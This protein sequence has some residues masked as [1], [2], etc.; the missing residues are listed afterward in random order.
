MGTGGME[1]AQE[2]RM[3]PQKPFGSES[4]RSGRFFLNVAKDGILPTDAP[5][6]RTKRPLCVPQK[7]ARQ[8][9]LP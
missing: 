6:R 4:I 7:F 2:G 8:V 5:R 9:T 1:E 3:T